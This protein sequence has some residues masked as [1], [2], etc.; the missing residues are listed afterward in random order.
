MLIRSG[1]FRR[2][3]QLQRRPC[4][5]LGVS[6]PVAS[7]ISNDFVIS[8][9]TSASG[10][11]V[12]KRQQKVTVELV[13]VHGGGQAIVGN[14]ESRREGL[15]RNQRINPLQSKLCMHLSP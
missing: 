7:D 14:V 3:K 11:L 15:T 1:S 9:R 8:S 5:E 4:R 10:R 2:C 13:H 12:G 6:P